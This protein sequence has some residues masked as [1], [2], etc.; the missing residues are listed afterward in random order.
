MRA[1]L[2]DIYRHRKGG[3]NHLHL[4]EKALVLQQLVDSTPPGVKRMVAMDIDFILE[5]ALELLEC[6]GGSPRG[7]GDP[8]RPSLQQFVVLYLAH[9]CDSKTSRILRGASRVFPSRVELQLLLAR[10]EFID[11]NIA[12]EEE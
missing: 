7:D 8:P 11:G 2:S 9:L 6:V 10:A 5:V 12:E 4:F 3:E 1:Q